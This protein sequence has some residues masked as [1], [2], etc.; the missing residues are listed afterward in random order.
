MI[1]ETE[2]D[3]IQ[4]V[5]SLGMGYRAQTPSGSADV[6]FHDTHVSVDAVSGFRMSDH[7]PWLKMTTQQATALQLVKGAAVTIINP[8]GGWVQYRVRDPQP[9]GTGMSRIELD[10]CP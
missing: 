3:R 6:I 5:Q 10:S 8:C 4:M 9:D 7:S 1:T 2:E